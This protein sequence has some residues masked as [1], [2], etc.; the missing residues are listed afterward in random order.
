M[1]DYDLVT[2]HLV[3]FDAV[4]LKPVVLKKFLKK[5]QIQIHFSAFMTAFIF[6]KHLTD[7]TAS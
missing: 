6:A 2:S 3:V 4:M 5:S 7:V 1:N